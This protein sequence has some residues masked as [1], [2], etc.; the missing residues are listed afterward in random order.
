MLLNTVIILLR[1]VLEIALLTSITFSYANR[2]QLK[3]NVLIVAMIAG[4]IGAVVYGNNINSVTLLFDGVGQEVVNACL[5]IFVYVALC[6][7]V[8]QA[9]QARICSS[10]YTLI[11]LI[12]FLT[13]MREGA[14]VYVYLEGALSVPARSTAV[15]FGALIGSAL[16]ISVGIIFYYL[17]VT[18]PKP[19]AIKIGYLMLLLQAGSTVAQ[20]AQLLMQADWIDQ[21]YPLWDSLWLI[22][23]RSLT[24]QMLYALMG[25]EATP[26]S[27]EVLFYI[28][29]LVIFM[30]ISLCK[31][32]S[33]ETRS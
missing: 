3:V 20:S 22:D 25:Y 4:L 33:N 23:E 21:T 7:F 19:I 17:L 2:M 6:V 5:H 16:G 11:T 18:T 26:T 32:D 15:A 14:E 31:K 27:K 13:V 8:R 1:E 10:I 12:I 9:L 30:V 28:A 29:S 24:G